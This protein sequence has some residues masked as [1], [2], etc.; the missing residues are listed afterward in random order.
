MLSALSPPHEHPFIAKKQATLAKSL[1]SWKKGS[2]L[3]EA[4][5][6]AWYLVAVGREESARSIVDE[7]AAHVAFTGNYNQW[8]PA[9]DSICMASR[10]AR[11]A[12]DTGRAA[13]LIARIVEQPA[14]A[15]G[16]GRD[17]F[18]GILQRNIT[19]LDSA[20]D[21]SNAQSACKLAA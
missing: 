21:S 2:A 13:A 5:F 8:G 1:T 15:V 18:K 17:Y 12:G 4:N 19:Q 10:F 20:G 14:Y 3:L 7:I 9:A 16:A 6:H 11:Q